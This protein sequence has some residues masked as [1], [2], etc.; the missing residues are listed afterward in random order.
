MNEIAV[1]LRQNWPTLL[2]ILAI[3]LL[4]GLEAEAVEIGLRRFFDGSNYKA[5]FWAPAWNYRAYFL[6]FLV[7]FVP[8]LIILMGRRARP[9]LPRLVQAA[10]GYRWPPILA[11]QV[12]SYTGFVILTYLLSARYED[13]GI[14]TFAVIAGWLA[15]TVATLALSLLA[16]APKGF[17]IDFAR[18]E[19]ITL[20]AA[21]AVSI[22]TTSFVFAI[23]N[24]T[25]L[26]DVTFRFSETL[27]R[28]FYTDIH[29]NAQTHALGTSGFQ[30]LIA[31]ECS[32]YEGIVLV[33]VF[34]SLYLWVFRR[35]FRFP[36]TL[37]VF[38]IGILVIWT[39]N[40]LRI[41][42]LIAI[43]TSFSPE[44][45][46]AG[47]HSNA[48]WIAFICVSV[49]LIW[50]AHRVPFFAA[51]T[52]SR[53]TTRASIPSVNRGQASELEALLV[54]F[55]VLLASTLVTSALTAGFDWLYPLK[56]LATGAAL[57]F[58]WRCYQFEQRSLTA[59]PFLVGALT[60]LGWILLVPASDEASTAFAIGL[61]AAPTAGA[62]IWLVFRFIGSAITV[63]FAEELAFRGYL[64]SRL[65]G[66]RPTPGGTVPFTWVSFVVSSL[67]F[68]VFH[69]AWIAGTL[70]GMAYAYARYRR[71]AIS[72]AIVAHMTTNALLS[73]Y[74]LLTQQWSYW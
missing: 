33:V 41:A 3:L 30:V 54:P 74:V 5:S 60:F 63:P 55:V 24:L 26:G 16:L 12:V 34:L 61:A 22:G 70:A 13:L 49:A 43:G 29:S 9:Y 71:G 56:V 64:L 37:I 72:D 28:L 15:A 36:Q 21:A 67:A 57:W 38:P 48:G 6:V 25:W 27:L 11:I 51:T 62:S 47:F 39:F 2:R 32:G 73:G 52:D 14:L 58:F 17:W 44:I 59:E 66:T 10:H 8:A 1:S 45:A 42:A 46:V 69:D 53:L 18:G 40:A 23:R 68:G 31:K 4:L 65:T 19:R 35:D 50:A 20:L 7:L